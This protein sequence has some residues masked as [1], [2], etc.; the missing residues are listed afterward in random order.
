MAVFQTLS[1]PLRSG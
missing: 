1:F